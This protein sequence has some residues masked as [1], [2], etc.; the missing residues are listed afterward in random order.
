MHN[1]GAKATDLS[2]SCVCSVRGLAAF[3]YSSRTTAATRLA[4]KHTIQPS[5][6]RERGSHGRKRFGEVQQEENGGKA[7][8]LD[9][10]AIVRSMSAAM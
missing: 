4:R 1:R 5:R 7:I 8:L 9:P 10:L 2:C 6:E 3:I